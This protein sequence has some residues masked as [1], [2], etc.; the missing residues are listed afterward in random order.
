MANIRSFKDLKVWQNAMDA[1]M[2]AFELT[3]GL[4]IKEKYSLTDQ[5]R[6][7][8]ARLHPIFPK[9]GGSVAILRLL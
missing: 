4:P 7:A 5:F 2:R 8:P 9:H 3:K 1:A 6:R